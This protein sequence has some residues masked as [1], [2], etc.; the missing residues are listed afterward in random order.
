MATVTICCVLLSHLE[1]YFLLMKSR[2]HKSTYLSEF[3]WELQGKHWSWWVAQSKNMRRMVPVLDYL[4][5][6]SWLPS[7]F[8]SPTASLTKVCDFLLSY[9]I[10]TLFRF[11]NIKTLYTL[12][13]PCSTY[14]LLWN[15]NWVLIRKVRS[16]I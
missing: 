1:S 12:L 10:S 14:P 4:L 8:F 6:S 3:F 7:Y 2:D 16:L 11:N 15:I 9:R 5:I 13:Y